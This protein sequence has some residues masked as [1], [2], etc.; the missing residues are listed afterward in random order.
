MKKI[1]LIIVLMFFTTGCYDYM[2]LN[3]L[4][5]ISGIAIDKD[6]DKYKV[7]FEILSDQKSGQ[8]T[9]TGDAITVNG[10]GT[11]IADAF[12]NASKEVPK[13][14]FYPHLK[15]LVLS[16]DIAKEKMFDIVDYVLRSPRI[17]NE[18]YVVITKEDK[19]SDIFTKASSDIKVVSSQIETMIKNNPRRKNNASPYTFEEIAEEFLNKR[20]DTAITAINLKNKE[21]SIE[22]LAVFNN[23]KLSGFLSSDGAYAY[24]IMIE[25]AKNIQ[26]TFSCGEEK[27]ITLSIYDA[28]P[29]IKITEDKKIEI[30]LDVK[31]SI[32]EYN[33]DK[34][35]KDPKTYAYFNKKYDSKINKNIE[36]FYKE[37][38]NKKTDILGI[39]D[40]YYRET[41]KNIDWTELDYK[42][43]TNLKINN[44]GL[45]FEVKND[46]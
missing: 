4:S 35:L 40:I 19:A 14:A 7:T 5:I 20:T 38:L 44:A 36:D 27:N 12:N 42:I 30:N 8:E 31:A 15:V 37:I 17:R 18:F 23:Y 6:G 21:I 39:E 43:N 24:N 33:C 22:G 28:S 41:R 16:E 32:V 1:I 10:S 46:N 26:Y 25:N 2:E 45:I 3:D 29:K 11:T 34:S 13:L 9:T